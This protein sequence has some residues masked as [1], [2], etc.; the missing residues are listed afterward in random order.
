MVLE[1]SDLVEKRENYYK[2][3]FLSPLINYF[4][5]VI[6]YFSDRLGLNLGRYLVNMVLELSGLVVDGSTEESLCAGASKVVCAVRKDWQPED[7]LFRVG[8]FTT[9]LKGK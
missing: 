5:H 2:L 1:L 8:T 7:L 3:S 9:F 4:T 6:L